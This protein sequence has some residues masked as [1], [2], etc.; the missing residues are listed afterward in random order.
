[1]SMET[2]DWLNTMCLIGYTDKRGEAWHYREASQGEESNHY[3]GPVPVPDILRRLFNFTVEERDVFV[4]R[5]DGSRE[6][7]RK[8]EGRKAMTC[9]DNGDVLGIFKDGYKGHSYQEWLLDKVASI[10]DD[11]LGV[12]SAGLL[13]GRGQAWVQIEVPESIT[14][15]EGVEFRPSLLA[16]TSYD[17]SLATTYG[18]KVQVVVCDNT[19]SAALSEGGQRLKIKH[20]RYSDLKLNDARQALAIVHSMGDAFAAEVANLTA[21]KVSEGAFERVLDLVLPLPDPTSKTKSSAPRK[22]EEI[23]Q[24]YRADERAAP[25]RG[26]AFGVLQ[27]FNTWQHHVATVKGESKGRVQRNYERA[28]TNVGEK[29]DADILTAIAAATQHAA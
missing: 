3:P 8:I 5:A 2:S 4:A 13:R 25:W 24:L 28:I 23:I 20:S 27:A 6:H 26:T 22:R 16:A 11:T 29:F 12:G 1:M 10:L 9:S 17:G 14:T 7:S 19:L 18:R 15:P 21:H